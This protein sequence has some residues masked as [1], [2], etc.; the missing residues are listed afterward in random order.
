MSRQVRVSPAVARKLGVRPKRDSSN[1]RSHP[2]AEKAP[3]HQHG[4]VYVWEREPR[5]CPRCGL[6]VRAL[7][8]RGSA[9]EFTC[10]GC[11]VCPECRR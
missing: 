4:V 10:A 2:D 1:E 9:G 7:Q 6:L 11:A 3:D 5:E 8:R